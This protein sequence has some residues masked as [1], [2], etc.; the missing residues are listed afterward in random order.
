MKHTVGACLTQFAPPPRYVL[1]PYIE[2][3]GARYGV[4]VKAKRAHT[5]AVRRGRPHII[6]R[7]P[8]VQHP[9]QGLLGLSRRKI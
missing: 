9:K 7:R 5:Q 4:S 8:R 6:V 1:R 3:M 2:D